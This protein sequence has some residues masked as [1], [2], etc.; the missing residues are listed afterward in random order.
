[1]SESFAPGVNISTVA[2]RHGVRGGLLHKWRGQA[3][4]AAASTAWR[5]MMA[6]RMIATDPAAESPMT[7]A[8]RPLATAPFGN[9][10]SRASCCC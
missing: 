6:E 5:R 3:K 7:A 8:S 4:Q 10:A 2:R 1:V 9:R